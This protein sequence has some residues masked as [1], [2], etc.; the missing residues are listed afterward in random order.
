MAHQKT[1]A[2]VSLLEREEGRGVF[3]RR[4]EGVAFNV[5]DTR[6]A[7][8]VNDNPVADS[9]AA[10]CGAT[11]RKKGIFIAPCDAK[12]LG[13]KFGGRVLPHMGVTLYTGGAGN[14]DFVAAGS[15]ILDSGV[16][17]AWLKAGDV[18]LCSGTVP[19]V[20]LTNTGPFTVVTVAAGDITVAE[21]IV[22]ELPAGTVSIAVA[23]V[24]KIAVNKAV[25]GGT[26]LNL[27]AAVKQIQTNT[28]MDCG[29]AKT[30]GTVFV[31]ETAA[32]N[33]GAA[34]D[35]LICDG[36]LPLAGDYFYVGA[37]KKFDG[38]LL[39]A[40]T[41]G[42]FVTTGVWQYYAGAVLGWLTFT[43]DED[44]TDGF[45]GVTATGYYKVRWD[46]ANLGGWVPDAVPGLLAC[47]HVRFKWVTT[48][49]H[50]TAP[51]LQQLWIFPYGWK[52]WDVAAA[53]A[54]V[55]YGNDVTDLALSTSDGVLFLLEGQE[56]Y[57]LVD[58]TLNVEVKS[59]ALRVEVEW[60]PQ[61]V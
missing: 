11:A 20:T 33:T 10:E 30:G 3:S 43:P 56:V 59:D 39:Y 25:I 22:G 53:P 51:L 6:G 57:L 1:T 13:I 28:L 24:C 32:A 16:G 12:V 4:I 26:D 50:V 7:S 18:I 14:I 54:C 9:I 49:S 5:A 58:T 60:M 31:D 44:E 46:S 37:G 34:N 52:D 8:D 17:L 27:L 47:Y 38:V 40:S 42:N 41:A 21:T 55:Y 35:V 19:A 29:Y 2:A 61:E 15:H 36:H 23:G 45:D 48:T